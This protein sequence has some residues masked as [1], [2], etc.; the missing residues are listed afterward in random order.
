MRRSVAFLAGLALLGAPAFANLLIN[1]GV[2]DPPD[3]ETDIATGWT[4][5]EPSLDGDG[6]PVNSAT[7]ASFANHTPGGARGLWYRSFEG[8]L[9]GDEPFEVDAHLYQD[10]SGTAGSAYT[11]SA[12]YRYETFYSGT[13]PFANTQ[14]ILAIDFLDGGGGVISSAELDIDSVQTPDGEWREFSVNGVAP[15]GTTTVRARSSMLGGVLEPQN[16][17]SAFVDDFNLVPEPT[18]ALL[19]VAGGLAL[20]RR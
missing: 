12:W 10:V 5:E 20:R 4:L 16:P 9:G 19:L 1:P 15:A 11:L 7:F 17:Q 8:G 14:T 18:S 13:D 6:N 2:D 3:H